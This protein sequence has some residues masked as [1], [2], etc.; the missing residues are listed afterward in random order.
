MTGFGYSYGGRFAMLLGAIT[1]SLILSD[2]GII[3]VAFATIAEVPGMVIPAFLELKHQVITDRL[4][5]VL[6]IP[7]FESSVFIPSIN[8]LANHLPQKHPWMK[9]VA[10]YYPQRELNTYISCDRFSPTQN[11]CLSSSLSDSANLTCSVPSLYSVRSCSL[12]L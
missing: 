10:F 5:T 4:I 12:S 9:C 7:K 3:W 8:S 1:C 6:S 2:Q 11:V